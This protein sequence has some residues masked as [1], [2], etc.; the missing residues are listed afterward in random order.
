MTPKEKAEELFQKFYD[1]ILG[2]EG[3]DAE[4]SAIKCAIICVDEILAAGN[5]PIVG[6]Y[7]NDLY[8]VEVKEEINKL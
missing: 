7:F 4:G 2:I 8:W 3:W 5:I 1:E 6:E